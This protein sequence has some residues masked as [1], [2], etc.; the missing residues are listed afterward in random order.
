MQGARAQDTCL[1]VLGHERRRTPLIVGD[2]LVLLRLVVAL[3]VVSGGVG[4]TR[5]DDLSM[6]LAVLI[7]L[8]LSNSPGVF[9]ICRLGLRLIVL[10]GILIEGG[11]VTGGVG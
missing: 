2:L 11:L 1:F 3:A 4:I 10:I 6:I 9:S 7:V 8:A 5:R